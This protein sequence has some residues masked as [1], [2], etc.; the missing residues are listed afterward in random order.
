[1]DLKKISLTISLLGVITLLILANTLEP[2]LTS[3]NKITIKELNKKV[4][5][6]GQIINIKNYEN[7]KT[8]ETFYILTISDGVGKIDTVLNTKSNSNLLNIKINQNVTI[9]G[10]V[11]QYKDKLQIQVEKIVI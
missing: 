4:R 6:Q 11:S 10:R 5:I 7:T 3:I 8:K 1:M 9:T 2:K